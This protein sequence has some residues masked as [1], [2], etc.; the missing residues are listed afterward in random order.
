[1]DE[2]WMLVWIIAD[3]NYPFTIIKVLTSNS[4]SHKKKITT[5]LLEGFLELGFDEL[6]FDEYPFDVLTLS[7]TIQ[8]IKTCPIQMVK[9]SS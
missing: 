9:L 3:R 2:K 8:L 1:M 5:E 6:P 4:I 7:H